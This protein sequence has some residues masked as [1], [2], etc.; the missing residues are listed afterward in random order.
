MHIIATY[1]GSLMKLFINSVKIAE[2]SHSGKIVNSTYPIFIGSDETAVHHYLEGKIKNLRIY[3][4]ALT[5]AEIKELYKKDGGT[6][7]P[8]TNKILFEED[9][10]K[11]TIGGDPKDWTYHSPWGDAGTIEIS[12]NIDN[13]S[14]KSLKV[15][16]KVG[17]A[18]G[19][20]KE[21]TVFEKDI[22]VSFDASIPAGTEVGKAT[23][24]FVY[25]G[26]GLNFY[27]T[28]TDKLELRHKHTDILISQIEANKW[29]SYSIDI[30][31]TNKKFKIESNGKS[32]STLDFSS[33]LNTDGGWASDISLYGNNNS[34]NVNTVYFD[35]IKIVEK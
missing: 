10:E 22:T 3:N 26:I 29:N 34:E 28:A 20:Y 18:Q 13:N 30:D 1:N 5:E 31:W 23:G 12:E 4:K 11:S 33:V 9:F 25:L 32:S 2:V 35:N 19:V 8:T 27:S 21:K 6:E 16:G 15:K 14:T 17:W 24:Y 7:T